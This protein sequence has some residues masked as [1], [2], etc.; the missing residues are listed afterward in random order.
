MT[1]AYSFKAT[2]AS[3]AIEKVGRLFNASIDDILNELLQN[4][5]RA[6][7]TNILIDQVFGNTVRIID[8][9][10]GL[11]NP[12]ALFSLGRSQWPET[13]I[14]SEDAAGMGFFALANRGATII[15]QRRGTEES[16]VIEATPDAFHG[17]QPV[18][19]RRGPYGHKGVM[20]M[21][22]QT[23]ADNLVA[24][25]RKAARF[26]PIPVKLNGETMPSTDFLDGADH[27]ELWRGIRIGI[28]A[29]PPLAYDRD[30]AN[31]HGATLRIP[32][33]DI[34]QRF[35]PSFQ[36]R[37]DVVDCAHLRLV[38]PA[39]KEVVR[40]DMYRALREEVERIY[41]RLIAATGCHSLALSDYQRAVAL[42][43]DLP[44]AAPSLR[45]FSPSFAESGRNELLAPQAL[46][47]DARIYQSASALEE[48]NFARAVSGLGE[49][50]PLFE[51]EAAFEGYS[52]Y[53]A[54]RTIAL[55]RY[56]MVIGDIVEEIGPD[57]SFARQGRPDRLE[58]VLEVS[59]DDTSETIV[60]DTDMIVAGPEYGSLDEMDIRVTR[61]TAMT[62]GKLEQFLIDA[63][64]SPSDDA[65]AGSW[66]Q[67][68]EWF[69]DQA[70]DM[71]IHLLESE[72]A[73][74]LN[75][76]IRTVERELVW[77]M[78]KTGSV[79]I[80][81]DNRVVSIDGLSA[82]TERTDASLLS[83]LPG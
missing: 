61:R 55:S 69:R 41:F 51:P 38:L 82:V 48:Q 39:R 27:I 80:R 25:V 15:A 79:T 8:D 40:D 62:P 63:L 76:I 77:R 29:K 71:S 32:L 46:N 34:G 33:P 10:A 65:E 12:R 14:R 18:E 56:R 4:A 44:E 6:G 78:P 59:G 67:Q 57:G 81:I 70:Q 28:F 17:R 21:F 45:P 26:S 3:E 54:I 53:D 60:L 73:A 36:A 68:E 43:I 35:H 72:T 20:I 1:D 64:F 11:E 5:R 30:N 47:P 42:G 31:F 19:V 66:E 16:W 22:E 75:A 52:W 50:P 24:A 74:D 49:T 23:Q 7:A 2:I 13:L 37:I 58:I 83:D 9:G